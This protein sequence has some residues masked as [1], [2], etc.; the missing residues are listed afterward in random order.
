M[1]KGLRIK[2]DHRTPSDERTADNL[3]MGTALNDGRDVL[4]LVLHLVNVIVFVDA[5]FNQMRSSEPFSRYTGALGGL[6]PTQRVLR[7]VT[8]ERC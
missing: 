5:P 2:W 7:C 1:P 3:R 8:R 6:E 4:D